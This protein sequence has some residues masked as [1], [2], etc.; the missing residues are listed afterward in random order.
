[1]T[2]GTVVTLLYKFTGEP[3]VAGFNNPFPDVAA[4]QYY[5]NAVIWAATNG[6]VTGYD[7]GLFA[8]QDLMTREQFAVVLFRY[9][10]ALGN[11][12]MDILMDRSYSDF[13]QISNYAQSAVNKTTMQGV[14]RDW[15][16]DAQNR[17]QPKANVT[18][19]ELAAVMR[20]WIESIGW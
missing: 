2:R 16:V 19:A 5:T 8:P 18:R 4:G 6:I 15:P 7:T 13:S 10:N 11:T 3:S 12:A 20:L 17:F 1:M 14:Y 9:Q